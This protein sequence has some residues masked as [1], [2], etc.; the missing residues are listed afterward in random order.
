MSQAGLLS[1]STS[2]LPDIETLT[3]NV[4][5]IVGPDA[6]FN[7]DIL[8]SGDIT[9]TG[10]PG[11]NTLTISDSSPTDIET[12]TGNAGGAVGPDG[13]DNINILGTGDITVTGNPGTNTLTISDS[14]GANDIETVT[15]DSGG[16]VGPDGSNNINIIGGTSSTFNLTEIQIIGTPGTNTLTVTQMNT[17]TGFK[18]AGPGGTSDLIT[19]GLGATAAVYIFDVRVV[20]YNVATP[21]GAGYNIFGTVRT[22]GAAATIAGT[23]D[24][25]VNE[26]AAMIPGDMNLIVSGNNVI[27]Q[28]T[29]P[30]GLFVEYTAYMTYTKQE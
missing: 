20:A 12:L 13:S 27:I 30:P 23:P 8:G 5:G 19:F 15:G 3:G 22:T 26:E 18:G 10:N 29:V 2:A 6:A 17:V 9:V 1:E 11:T 4:G 28:A 16:I 21:A 24:K 14:S 25:I 7:I